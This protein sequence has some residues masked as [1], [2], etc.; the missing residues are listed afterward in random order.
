MRE[1]GRDLLDALLHLLVGIGGAL[2]RHLGQ[3]V[4]QRRSLLER[5]LAGIPLLLLQ[6]R[7][8]QVEV[9]VRV[10]RV[11]LDRFQERFLGVGELSGLQRLDGLV[12]QVDRLLLL[13]L[14]LE[15][16]LLLVVPR[17]ELKRDGFLGRALERDELVEGRL[18]PV[19]AP[20]DPVDA[21]VELR[22]ARL[23]LAVGLLLARL[24]GAE[25]LECDPGAGDRAA[26]GI[27]ALDVEL[28]IGPER[29]SAGDEHRCEQGN[30]EQMDRSDSCHILRP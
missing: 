6:V 26:G 3:N 14:V 22:V 9:A 15:V 27:D 17:L 2:R 1:L 30:A 5:F 7:D 20:D 18:E 28:R 4:G 13:G 11:Q 19:L 10:R 25:H 16:E 8:R 23:P 24:S 12:E 29:R 21:V